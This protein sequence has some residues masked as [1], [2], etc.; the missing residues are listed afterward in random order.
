MLD[1]R[2]DALALQPV[3]QRGA[4]LAGQ[5]GVLRE[6]LEVAPA[7]RRALHVD[8]G[9]EQHGDPVGPAFAAERLADA[10]EQAGVPGGRE[11]ERLGGK[12]VAGTLSSRPT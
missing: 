12:Q 2:A 8:A 10:G 9:P 6:V 7:Q 4:E 3:D 5:Q 11:A 1:R